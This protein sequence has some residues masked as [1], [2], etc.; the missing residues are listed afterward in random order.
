LDFSLPADLV[1]YLAELDRF[2]AT[3]I[4]PIENAD[5][6]IRFFDHRREYAC[7]TTCRTNTPSSA[8]CRW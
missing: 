6:N 1:A 7:T 8:I 4:K 2:I 5:D 3:Q